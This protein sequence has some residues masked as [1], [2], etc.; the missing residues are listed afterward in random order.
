M[1]RLFQIMLKI[2]YKNKYH[3]HILNRRKLQITKKE[4]KKEKSYNNNLNVYCAHELR[5][6]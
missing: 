4:K 6:S 1:T 5:I 3:Q 2:Y